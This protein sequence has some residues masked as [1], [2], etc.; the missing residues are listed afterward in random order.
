MGSAKRT[1]RPGSW[2]PRRGSAKRRARAAFFTAPT[3]PAQRRYEALRAYFVEG[4]TAR[5]AA[6]RFGYAPAS[7]VAMARDFEA[8]PREFFVERRPGPRTAPAKEAARAEV[9]RLRRE[10]RS[11][12]EIAA[13]L[14]S[15]ETPLNRTGVWELLRVEGFERLGRRAL[16]AA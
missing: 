4:A 7:V 14:E 3:D 15:S 5:E 12:T 9:V 6:E 2:P 8:D 16:A 11:V 13:L 10:R 1:S